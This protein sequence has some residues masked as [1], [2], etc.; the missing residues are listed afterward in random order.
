MRRLTA[1]PDGGN[2]SRARPPRGASA[3]AS[4][5]RLGGEVATLRVTPYSEVTRFD[6]ARTLGGRGRYWTTCY[7]VDGLLIDS[8]C[9]HTAPELERA[10]AGKPFDR[11]VNTHSHEDHIGANG[12]L[13]RRRDV[14]VLAHADALPVLAEPRRQR[15]HAYRRV[16]W[17]Y[18]EPSKGRALADGDEIR[19]PRFRFIALHTPGHAPD[20]LC[21]FEPDRGWLFSGDLYIGGRDRALREEYD[22]W[23]ILES[24][25]RVAALPVRTLFPGSARIPPDPRAA[26]DAKVAYYRQM[27]ERV[28]RLRAEGLGVRAIAREV[29]GPPMAMEWMTG[30]NFSRRGLVESYLRCAPGR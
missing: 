6:L 17:G 12:R 20:H 22:I 1:G 23:G 7:L 3:L 14:D 24:L 10:L 30:F 16:F 11:I 28:L 25:R 21:L 4:G 2:T 27:G 26:L 19:T 15:L 8:G 18:P 13:Q 5:S 9:A 29:C